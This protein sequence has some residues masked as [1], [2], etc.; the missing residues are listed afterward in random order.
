MPTDVVMPQMGESI[1]EGTITKWLKKPGDTVQ[2]DEPLF[3]ISTDKVDAEIPSPVAGT[4]SEIKV[5][6]GATVGI[7]TV[8]ATIAEGGNGAAA[9]A[10]AAKSEPAAAAPAAAATPA[11]AAEAPAAAGPGTEVL[12]PQM[13]E[14]ITEGTITKWL[15]KVG[16]TVQRDEPIFEIS[17]DKVDAEIPSPVAGTLTEIKIGEG[18]TVGINTVVAVIGGA[19]GKA[20]AAPAASAPAPA[21]AAP[22]AP[23]PAAA[24]ASPSVS[25]E[26]VRSSPLVR[27]IAK[28]NNL[29]LTQVSGTGSSGRITKT[30]ILGHLE[31]G[32]KPAPAAAA[33]AAASKP[34]P[35]VAQPQ[36]G[37]LVPMSKMRSIIAQRMVESK[38]TSPHVHTVF[39][40]DMTR[41]VKLREKEKSKY[42]QRNGVKLTYMPFI[43]RAAIVALRKH[44]IVNAAI[45]GD[46][47]RYN[48]NIN[49]G[50]AVALDWGLIVPVLKQTEEKNF[51]GI[52]RGIVDV[53]ERARGKK[54][55]PDEISGGTF[56]LTNSGI[57]GEQFGTPIINQP[58]SAILG[59]GG[60]NKEAEV[61]TDKDGNDVIAIRSIQRFT[62]GFDH[63]IVD[64]ADAGKFM[65]DF[66]AYL[67][68]WN[69]DIG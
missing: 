26:G 65:S 53:A 41:I 6:E 68:N 49:I 33:P 43:T 39:K 50:I 47:V 7:N 48:K 17:T 12:M 28:D 1:T 11:P 23:A 22:A 29:D 13:G 56:T 10:P 54:L 18:K 63:R 51:L 59:I 5:T 3:E 30:D 31:G 58:Q 60:L 16:D 34:A 2:R 20:A 66:K 25:T 64:G 14:S 8:V 45:E 36:P 55:A 9:A 19:A 57:F 52:A 69:E 40:V 62:L 21:A 44:P 38:R 24:A 46:A 42:E 35:A 67:E 61:L 27:K 4:L 32:A 37:E 15:K